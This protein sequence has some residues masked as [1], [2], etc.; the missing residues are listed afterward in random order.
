MKNEPICCPF[1]KQILPDTFLAA[2]LGSRG[3]RSRSKAK[4]EAGRANV[5]KA[6]AAL[7][8]KRREK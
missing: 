1:C 4:V 6:R 2:N 7:D 8:A 5:A 3:G